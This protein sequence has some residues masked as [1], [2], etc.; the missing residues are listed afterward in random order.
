VKTKLSLSS[1]GIGI[2]LI[3]LGF[4]ESNFLSSD[5]EK[6]FAGSTRDAA[7]WLLVVGAALTCAGVLMFARSVLD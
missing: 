5:A 7:I 1:I 4:L 3:L 6:F 2:V